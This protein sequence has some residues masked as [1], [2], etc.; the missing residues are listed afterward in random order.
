LFAFKTEDQLRAMMMQLTDKMKKLI[1]SLDFQH[2][3]SYT[4]KLLQSCISIFSVK[5]L[6]FSSMLL[7]AAE[8]FGGTFIDTKNKTN[9]PALLANIEVRMVDEIESYAL[10]EYIPQYQCRIPQ[11]FQ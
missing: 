6:L 7:N 9:I 4:E 1:L 2:Y 10:L 8:K 5:P 3:S 11:K